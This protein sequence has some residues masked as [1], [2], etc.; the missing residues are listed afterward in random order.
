MTQVLGLLY[1]ASTRFSGFDATGRSWYKAKEMAEAQQEWLATQEPGTAAS[2][3]PRRPSRQ[4]NRPL[5]ACIHEDFLVRV[6]ESSQGEHRVGLVDL[7]DRSATSGGFPYEPMIHPKVLIPYVKINTIREVS[8][9]TREAI[10][11]QAEPRRHNIEVGSNPLGGMADEYKLTIDKERG[12]LIS[13]VSLYRGKALLGDEL[14]DVKFKGAVLQPTSRHQGIADVV[15]LLYG[16]RYSFSTLRASIRQWH[17][18]QEGTSSPSQSKMTDAIPKTEIGSRLWIDNPS[19]FRQEIATRAPF[20]GPIV[21]L[22]NGDIWWQ[23]YPSGV[24]VTNSPKEQIPCGAE[25]KVLSRPVRPDYKNAEYAILS[26]ISL[27]PSWLISG[28]RMEP[29]GRMRYVGRET[30]RVQAEPVQESDGWYWWKGADEY[31]LLIDAERGIL[32]RIEARRQG[33]GFAGV[34]VMDIEFDVSI[35]DSAFSFT[36]SPGMSV[37]V[38]PPTP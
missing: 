32:L 19:R 14:H 13:H 36:V 22:L 35:P 28:L 30:I 29:V 9:G 2:I 21:F 24:T 3:T 31:E 23:G 18:Y 1:T 11:L 38:N 20:S 7:Q 33:E 37:D 12:I 6:Q 5:A 27:E 10:E 16:A 8:V 15:R 34:E 4:T 26:Q 25:V 17:R